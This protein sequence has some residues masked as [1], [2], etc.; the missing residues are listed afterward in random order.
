[1]EIGKSVK[2]GVGWFLTHSIEDF[3]YKSVREDV[4]FTIRGIIWMSLHR[5]VNVSV[6]DSIMDVVNIRIKL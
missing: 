1:M 3:I 4:H 5:P 2:H 6:R